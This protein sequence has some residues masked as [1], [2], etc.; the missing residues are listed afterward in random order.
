[1]PEAILLKLL[2]LLW[3]VVTAG[4]GYWV[5]ELNA[6]QNRATLRTDRVVEKTNLNSDRITR[7]ESETI[8][9]VEFAKQLAEME[10]RIMGNFK[11]FRLEF[12][13]DLGKFRDDLRDDLKEFR[14]KGS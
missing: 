14:N 3:F 7:L 8:T 1:M 11:D 4:V 6:K 10:R 13:S 2:Y 9:E 5:K 12:K